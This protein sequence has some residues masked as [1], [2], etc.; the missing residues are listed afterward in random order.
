ME[1][2][3]GHRQ[4]N[5]QERRRRKEEEGSRARKMNTVMGGWIVERMERMRREHGGSTG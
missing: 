1:R 3:G 5:R 4:N 2:R